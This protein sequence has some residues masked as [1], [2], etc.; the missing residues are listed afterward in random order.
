MRPGHLGDTSSQGD[1]P[2][3]T[4]S[5][6]AVEAWLRREGVGTTS[7]ACCG[8]LLVQRVGGATPTR[9]PSGFTPQG[10]VEPL[11]RVQTNP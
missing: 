7:S 3:D 2:D 4:G 9:R 11:L 1:T 5:A 10:R 8:R 6:V